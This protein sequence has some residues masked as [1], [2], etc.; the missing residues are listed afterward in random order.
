MTIEGPIVTES[1]GSVV[2]IESGDEQ[3]WIDR[4]EYFTTEMDFVTSQREA[5]ILKALDAGVSISAC[6]RACGTSRSVIH[7]VMEGWGYR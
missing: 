4:I 3:Y 1:M 2:E 5:A 6:A 7:K